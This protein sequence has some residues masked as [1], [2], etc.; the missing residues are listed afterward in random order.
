MAYKHSC[1][2]DTNA[3]Y[4]TLVL[5]LLVEN[6]DHQQEEQIQHYEMLEGEMLVDTVP[7]TMRPY[8]GAAGFIRPKWDAAASAWVEG[9]TEEEVA[10]WE[11][12]HPAP[13]LP[14]SV[15]TAEDRLTALEGAMLAMMGVRTDV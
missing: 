9:A 12:E 11:A 2:V 1:V 10:A 13:E 4:K 3:I 6:E 8:A 7:P 15:P 14:E 5:V